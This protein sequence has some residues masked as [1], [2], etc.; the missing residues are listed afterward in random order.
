[1]RSSIQAAPNVT[2]MVDVMLVLLII[3][4]VVAPTL[5]DGFVAEPPKATHVKD[6][7]QD[8]ADVTLGI[9]G[10]GRYFLNKRL[11]D[12]ATLVSR[13]Q[14]IFATSREERVLYLKADRDLD[15]SRVLTAIDIA[16][17]NGVGMI[18]MVTQQPSAGPKTN[19]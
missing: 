7:P 2:P 3:F 18:G 15:Y 8:S 6:Y 10:L 9:D 1:M 11:V 17:N 16:R 12:S 13:L 14:T 5:L 4:M 19:P